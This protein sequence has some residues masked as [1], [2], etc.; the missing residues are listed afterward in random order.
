MNKRIVS[1]LLAVL[2]V[3]ALFC[4]CAGEENPADTTAATTTA[5]TTEATT[6]EATT[7]EATTT[8]ATTTEATTT[9]ATTTEATT[10]EDPFDLSKSSTWT[11]DQWLAYEQQLDFGGREFILSI[12]TDDYSPYSF[13][14]GVQSVRDSEIC[15][16]WDEVLQQLQD[17]L[18][19]TITYISSLGDG[20]EAM[21]YFMAGDCP[22]D[23]YNLKT[24]TWFPIYSIGGLVKLN[25]DEML[26]A[27]LD[28]NNEKLFYQPFT[29]AWDV[30]GDTYGLRYAS[31][32]LPPEAGW[33]LFYN[34]DLVAA[35]GTDICQLVRD[36]DWTWDAFY[37][38]AGKLTQDTDGD[39]TNDIW[40]IATGYLG[41]GEEVLLTGGKIVDWQDGKLTSMINSTEAMEAYTFMDKVA[42]SGYIVQNLEGAN[43]TYKE[44]HLAFKTGTV[45]L[46]WSEMP[47]ARRG[48]SGSTK[49]AEAEISW[50]TVP[51]PKAT[52]EADYGNIL[53]GV[54]Y[55]CM[56]ITNKTQAESAAIYAAYSRRQNTT[57][58]EECMKE[59]LQDYD[60]E[61]S[62]E[63]IRDY[64]FAKPVA[65]WSWCS[66]EHND[67]YRAELVYKIF[68]EELAPSSLVESVQPKLQQLL[69]ALNK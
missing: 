39:G 60:D 1:L 10:T 61:E 31:K 23:F 38:L 3:A 54:R 44:G 5:A 59:Y 69:D 41:F 4:A 13:T 14:D 7:T 65:N 20:A 50:G 11:D 63:M 37:E 45:G 68:D 15:A 49:L 35:T 8:E 17:D 2:M 12:N 47:L 62:L 48:L 16:E 52:K 28:V 64:I 32:F 40:G 24:H 42:N 36:G 34:K 53:G 25:S 57:D 56:F 51:T 55:D 67:T 21:T 58:V 22:A 26:A 27:G 19:I 66:V 9:E 43:A 6:T 29:H 18:N 30:K 33:V 46:L